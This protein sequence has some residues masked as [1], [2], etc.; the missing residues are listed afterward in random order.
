MM[1]STE[2]ININIT[3]VLLFSH[4]LLSVSVCVSLYFDGKTGY[5]HITDFI[6][7][8]ILNPIAYTNF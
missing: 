3:Q 1:Q 8:F 5:I 7:K 6:S 4:K 2:I